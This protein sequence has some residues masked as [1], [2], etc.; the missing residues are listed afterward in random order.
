MPLVEFVAKELVLGVPGH[1]GLSGVRPKGWV[2]SVT[3]GVVKRGA[4]EEAG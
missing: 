3:E 2:E 1:P 4:A